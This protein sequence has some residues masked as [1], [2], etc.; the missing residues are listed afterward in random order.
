VV[1]L[2]ASG[3]SFSTGGDVLEFYNHRH[4]IAVYAN[5]LL[6]LL[7]RVIAAMMNCPVPIVAAVHGIVTGGSLG[8]VLGADI[9]LIT[10]ETSFTPYYS[11]VGFSP[12]GGWTAIL[13]SL[14]GAQR[15]A[16]ILI[17]NRSITAEQ[18]VSWGLAN[19]IV[20]SEQIQAEALNTARQIIKIA[21]VS[22]KMSKALLS[23]TDEQLISRLDE[24]R[25]LF[26]DQ[27]QSE[28][29]FLGMKRF[30]NID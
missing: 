4:E 8:L 15:V 14:I 24:E 3:P 9:I 25:T 7:N 18:A 26:I 5:E 6:G 29:A 2:K 16:E 17:C 19:R 28:E 13:P 20:P 23:S 22:V 10:P 1:I 30:L 11:E 21:P 12:D 27:I